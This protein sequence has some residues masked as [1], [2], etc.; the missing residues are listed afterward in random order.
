MELPQD[1]AANVYGGVGGQGGL[2]Q[3]WEHRHRKALRAL[4]P[5][6]PQPPRNQF[7][8]GRPPPHTQP[9]SRQAQPSLQTDVPESAYRARGGKDGAATGVEAGV[10]MRSPVLVPELGDLRQGLDSFST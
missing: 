7:P 1:R 4:A 6:M 10:G 2:L 5:E 8:L 3:R 9:P